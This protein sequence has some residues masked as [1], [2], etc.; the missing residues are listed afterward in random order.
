MAWV[1]LCL[2]VTN[3]LAGLAAAW[4]LALRAAYLRQIGEMKKIVEDVAIAASARYPAAE[5]GEQK[6]FKGPLERVES[7]L[8]SWINSNDDGED[9][10]L[11]KDQNSPQKDNPHNSLTEKELSTIFLITAAAS[12]LPLHCGRPL[13]TIQSLDLSGARMQLDQIIQ[14]SAEL[15]NHLLER[16]ASI[17]TVSGLATEFRRRKSFMPFL[18]LAAVVVSLILAGVVSFYVTRSASIENRFEMYVFE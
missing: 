1:F 2:A 13:H 15:Q 9:T 18:L 8:T 12:E 3:L 6:N 5:G 14:Q 11:N 10:L 4:W 7:Q 17:E 16:E